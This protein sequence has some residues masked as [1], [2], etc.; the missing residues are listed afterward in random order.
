VLTSE[1]RAVSRRTLLRAAGLGAAT[2]G[3][4]AC[5]PGGARFAA[6]SGGGTK[7]KII[8]V[9]ME[10]GSPYETFYRA[11]AAR[12]TEETGIKVKFLGVPH[13]N[14]QQVFLSDALS[15]AGAYDVYESD[16]PWIPQFAEN[17]F[18]VDLSDLVDPADRADFA[19]NT[20]DTVS[21]GGKLYAL[22]FLVHNLVLYYRT[23]LFERAGIGAPPVTWDEY[24]RFARRLTD[25]PSGV[26]GTLVEGKQE[27]ECAIHLEAFIQQAGGDICDSALR[28]TIDT[29]PAASAA[30]F[31]TALVADGSAPGGLFDLT[32]MQ[33]QFLDGKLAMAPVWPFLYALASDPSQSKVAGKFA[34][35][36]SPGNPAQVA[37]TF[38]WGFAISSAS[39]NRDAAWAW[40]NWA[41]GT[42]MQAEFGKN[43]IN[44]V[45]RIS[46]VHKVTADPSLSEADRKAIAVF[47][48]SVRRSKTMPM[49]PKYPQWEDAIAVALSSIMSGNQGPATA[50]RS[51]QATM[52]SPAAGV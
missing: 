20:L 44:P 31:M 32:D 1:G 33:G 26:H 12:F 48:D 21:Y 18:L 43:Q 45:P 42:D 5:A 13:D 34:V 15:G 50:L 29:R 19:G 40:V 52:S 30:R 36:L 10:A 3:V 35:A 25:R 28:P 7:G 41:T 11:K 47:A 22:P 46:A 39:R 49:T 16:Q 6:G 38:S 4:A 9:G 23:D 51:A 14:M 27:G 17:G 24:R 2:L 8:T 37:T